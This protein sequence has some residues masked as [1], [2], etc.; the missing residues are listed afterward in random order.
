M[1]GS[2][3]VVGFLGIVHLRVQTPRGASLQGL[4]E[5]QEQGVE[6]AIDLPAEVVPEVRRRV[7]HQIRLRRW[8]VDVAAMLLG[9][10]AETHTGREQ[11]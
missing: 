6:L 11:G 7:S 5:V 4:V 8:G 10:Q 2:R 9:E 1:F 3:E